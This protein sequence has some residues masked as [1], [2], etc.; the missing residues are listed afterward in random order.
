MCAGE[1]RCGAFE[2]LGAE[3]GLEELELLG[4]IIDTVPDAILAH[5]P[6]GNLIFF[7]QGAC[8]LY[9]YTPEEMR[10]LRPFGWV[11]PE[12]MR[13]AAGRL[14]TILHEGHLLFE[15]QA[16]LKD[17]TIVPTE[18]FAR[19]AESSVGPVVVAVVHD[20]TERKRAQAELVHLAYH[21][22]L[23]GL[24]NRRAFED[25]LKLAI[26]DAKRHN[27]I[28]GLVYLDLDRFKPVNDRYGHEVGDEVLTAVAQ[29]LVSCVREQDMVARLGGDEFVILLPRMHSPEE[30]PIL[31][32][33]VLRSIRQPIAAC[34]FECSVDATMGFAL[35]DTASDDSRSL[36]AKA[37]AAMY[38][39]KQAAE[40]PWVMWQAD[41]VVRRAERTE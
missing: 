8:D 20:I 33:R 32:E 31:A 40:D 4:L 21:D 1:H 5:G 26:A 25:R 19:K 2:L 9:G 10:D 24:P 22:S 39:A 41:M 28:L 12:A 7:S 13:G 14:E 23:T 37:D 38:L 36:V 17:G 34:G 6:S 3:P 29:R 11:A 30:F 35:Y 16:L 18:V 15:S 27:D